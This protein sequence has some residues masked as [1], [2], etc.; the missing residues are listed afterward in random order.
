VNDASAGIE[1]SGKKNAK[2][3]KGSATLQ[4][5]GALAVTSNV[6]AIGRDDKRTSIRNLGTQ[7]VDRDKD[8]MNERRHLSSGHGKLAR[9]LE[10]F[11]A[12]RRLRKEHIDNK[13]ISSNPL[14]F[15]TEEHV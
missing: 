15:G 2:V 13:R 6:S 8:V 11:N 3:L 4:M 10:K 14:L 7:K 1:P 5:T 9:A 12:Y